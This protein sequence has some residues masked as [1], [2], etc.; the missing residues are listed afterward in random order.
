M[1]DTMLDLS[2]MSRMPQAVA[3]EMDEDWPPFGSPSEPDDRFNGM[4]MRDIGQALAG[5]WYLDDWTQAAATFFL[6]G[7]DL[8]LRI[9]D[10]TKASLQAYQAQHDAFGLEPVLKALSEYIRAHDYDGYY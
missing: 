5:L 7:K 3:R 10:Q 8:A 1:S 2:L 4:T 9:V 6:E